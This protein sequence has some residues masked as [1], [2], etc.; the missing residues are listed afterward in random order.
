MEEVPQNLINPDGLVSK[1]ADFSIRKGDITFIH[2][3]FITGRPYF[4]TSGFK[5]YVLGCVECCDC[6][7]PVNTVVIVLPNHCNTYGRRLAELEVRALAGGF[8]AWGKKTR[9]ISEVELVKMLKFAN[10]P[11]FVHVCPM[12]PEETVNKLEV[13]AAEMTLAE[14]CRFEFPGLRPCVHRRGVQTQ[15]DLLQRYKEDN[16][17][18]EGEGFQE[19]SLTPILDSMKIKKR[20]GRKGSDDEWEDVA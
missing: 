6:D 11:R 3:R 13:P 9:A 7:R 10:S 4:N 1:L 18:A 8:F 2:C 12:H 5:D 16:G 14:A 19:A 17:G 15:E 20:F